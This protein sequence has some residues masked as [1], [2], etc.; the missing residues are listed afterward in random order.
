[1][2]PR[3]YSKPPITEALCEFQFHENSPWDDSILDAIYKKFK[4]DF[5]QRRKAK[6]VTV[7]FAADQ[8]AI[9]QRAH[10][11]DI[12]QFVQSDGKTIVQVGEHVLV[13][14][15]LAPYTSWQE[16]SSL[17]KRSYETYTKAVQPEIINR[18]GVRYINT[19]EFEDP[20]IRMEDYFNFYRELN[21]E[22]GLPET[23]G[24]FFMGLGFPFADGKDILKLEL[25]T[26]TA[27]V[28]KRQ[29]LTLNLDYYT[30]EPITVKSAKAL[31]W[32]DK[33]HAHI[34]EIFEAGIKDKLR[35]KFG[36][37]EDQ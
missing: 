11:K 32:V 28:A 13:I 19:I 18:I 1:M 23:H 17:I 3:R 8:Q 15:H 20:Q 30:I 35:E 33:A 36:T 37:Q 25:G 27:S 9:Q 5:P 29:A 2:K 22:S 6:R 14:N 12:T 24:D 10:T 34:E 21:S 26:A 7:E 31:H 16:F 4:R